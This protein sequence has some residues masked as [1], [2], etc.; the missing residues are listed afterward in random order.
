ML[1]IFNVF[2]YF[3]QS[4]GYFLPVREY[5]PINAQPAPGFAPALHQENNTH[6]YKY[7]HARKTYA[8]VTSSYF[9]F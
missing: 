7:L 6:P 2:M 9:P 8:T 4:T 3:F 5:M 1:L